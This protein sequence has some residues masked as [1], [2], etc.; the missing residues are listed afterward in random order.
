[1]VIS[2]IGSLVCRDFVRGPR[3]LHSCRDGEFF[4]CVLT[5]S[6]A[7]CPD[8]VG[9]FRFFNVDNLAAQ[10]LKVS[11]EVRT[12]GPLVCMRNLWDRY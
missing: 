7:L 2:E 1:M 4:D 5:P 10:Q 6:E 12:V 9:H 11:R 8:R 3:R